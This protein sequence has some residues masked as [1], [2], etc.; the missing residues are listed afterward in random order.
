MFEGY[1]G[2]IIRKHADG[3]REGEYLSVNVDFVLLPD[4]TFALLLSELKDSGG[5]IWDKEKVLV[6][7]DHFAPPSTVERANIAKK[8]I[9]YAMDEKLPHCSVHQGICHQ[10][11]VEGSWLT[12][13]MLVL[14]ADSHTTTAR[15]LGCLE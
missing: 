11:L 5:R 13:G 3:R 6:T 7:V 12:P 14:G 9:S 10:L 4:P 15:A 8:V 1:T 2:E